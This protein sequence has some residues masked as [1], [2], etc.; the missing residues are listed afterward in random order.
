MELDVKVEY[1]YKDKKYIEGDYSFDPLTNEC[2]RETLIEICDDLA[3]KI[4][5]DFP[6]YVSDVPLL[7]DEIMKLQEIHRDKIKK[8]FEEDMKH[9]GE[10]FSSDL[11][12]LNAIP[13]IEINFFYSPK[14]DAYGLPLLFVLSDNLIQVDSEI[15]EKIIEEIIFS[16]KV[17]KSNII[18]V[19]ASDVDYLEVGKV[20][21]IGALEYGG[22]HV[23][24]S[25][26]VLEPKNEDPLYLHKIRYWKENENIEQE[27]DENH[28]ISI[29]Y[30]NDD[31]MLFKVKNKKSSIAGE[32]EH[33]MILRRNEQQRIK[34][35]FVQ[36]IKLAL[37]EMRFS[38]KTVLNHQGKRFG[39]DVSTLIVLKSNREMYLMVNSK[40]GVFLS[41]SFSIMSIKDE[42]PD[43]REIRLEKER[44]KLAVAEE[45]NKSS[46]LSDEEKIALARAKMQKVD[47]APRELEVEE[48]ESVEAEELDSDDGWGA[49]MEE[50][51]EETEDK[52]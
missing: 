3:Q 9:Q 4:S 24:G 33:I 36:L 43:I 18:F 34:M 51:G 11:K 8:Q 31:D 14:N 30:H 48:V 40:E 22:L 19:L 50:M 37:S 38:L 25:D 15:R 20:E 42:L 26:W 27:E 21:H 7:S 44:I 45:K 47:D 23:K 32:F 41:E 17:E 5:N 29:S 10:V 28:L 49:L 2:E 6:A 52:Y 1:T 39:T 35:L 12:T 13:H 46:E 16:E